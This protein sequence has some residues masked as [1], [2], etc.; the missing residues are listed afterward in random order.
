MNHESYFYNCSIEYIENIEAGLYNQITGIIANLN[1]RETQSEINNDFFWLLVSN[2]WS[3]DTLSGVSEAPPS[4]LLLNT[5][6]SSFQLKE[7]NNRALCKT[8]S[9]IEADWHSDFAKT[10]S[11]KLVQLEVQFGK[12]ESMFKDFCGFKIAHYENRLS[13]GV[14][15]VMSD[16]GKYFAHRKSSISG[17]A[18]FDI[19]RNTLSAIGLNCPIWLIGMKE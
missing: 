2:G 16:P 11:G 12:V 19:A 6:S 4:D 15:I 18:Y 7:N 5:S 17:M 9:T 14:E 3:F 13:L 10:Y 8:T 1:K